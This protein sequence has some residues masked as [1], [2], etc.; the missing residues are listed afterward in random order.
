MRFLSPKI[1]SLKVWGVIIWCFVASQEEW[2]KAQNQSKLYKEQLSEIITTV[3]MA[4]NNH[5]LNI[6]WGF[7]KHLYWHVQETVKTHL[8]MTLRFSTFFHSCIL[9]GLFNFVV[10][11]PFLFSPNTGL[12]R[13]E[14]RLLYWK[15][16]QCKYYFLLLDVVVIHEK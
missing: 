13:K 14:D 7:Y 1:W 3:L 11:S 15:Q 8:L 9:K 16:I 6:F 5:V 12:I 2:Q 4:L 10:L